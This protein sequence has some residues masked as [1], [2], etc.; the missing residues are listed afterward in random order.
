MTKETTLVLQKSMHKVTSGTFYPTVMRCEDDGTLTVEWLDGTTEDLQ[1][2]AGDDRDM[3]ETK[4]V[5]VV[6]GTF[7]FSDK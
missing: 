1:F 4:S 5:T 6:S 7:S 3:C 2:I